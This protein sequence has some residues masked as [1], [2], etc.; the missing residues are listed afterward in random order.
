M[1]NHIEKW[2][3]VPLEKYRQQT[4][5][6]QRRI[7]SSSKRGDQK[8]MHSLQQLLIG[9]FAARCVAVETVTEINAGKDTAGVDGKHSLTDPQ[10]LRL[11]RELSLAQ[12][13]S[14]VRRVW[15]EK[16]GSVE[17]RPLGIPTLQDRALQALIA[18]ALEPQWEARFTGGM[19][20][21]RKGR[22]CHD[23]IGLIRSSI[24]FNPKWVLDA[25]IEKFFDRVNHEA[26]LEKLN[27]FPLLRATIRR[28]LKSGVLEDAILAPSVEGTPQGGVLSPLL[29]NVCLCGLEEVIKSESRIWILD[30]G[31]KPKREPVVAIYADDFVVLHERR[32][33]IERTRELIVSWL[34]PMGLTL[35]PEKTTIVHTLEE[36]A[37]KA[38]FDF[39]G[40]HI[41]QFRTGKHAVKPCFKQIHTHINPSKKAIKRAY[42]R[43]AEIIDEMIS[44]PRGAKEAGRQSAEEILIH[45]LN[46]LIRGWS[47]YFRYANS[48]RIFSKLDH[49]VWWKLWRSLIRRHRKMGRR[50]IVDKFFNGGHPW[51]FNCPSN[52]P[53]GK[54]TLIHFA[55][56]AIARH[57][58]VR[59]E[60]S[61]YDG[62]WQ[63]WATRR[64]SYPALPDSTARLL[65]RQHGKCAGCRSPFESTDRFEIVLQ[66]HRGPK[67]TFPRK[68]L[69]HVRCVSAI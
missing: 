68:A 8:S 40:H 24:Q 1:R 25:D 43:A 14:P 27:T 61:F 35:H 37:G 65:K 60:K 46:R 53:Q 55:D 56:T 66:S 21:F 51:Q 16:P 3:D 36:H 49:L 4:F 13:I 6:L 58:S 50:E 41:Q 32:E 67:G 29:A 28:L 22:S 19:F 10:K 33:V 9:S 44:G 39:L 48:K 26:L 69:V 17:K 11:A 23:A 30:D 47:N 12:E 5:R 52:G 7:F 59:K 15:I 45:R 18:L 63:Y 38:G 57:F 31:K 42:Q 54:A 64:G 2:E 34:K 62:D 20:G